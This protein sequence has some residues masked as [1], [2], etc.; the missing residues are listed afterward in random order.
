MLPNLALITSVSHMARSEACQKNVWMPV[1][2]SAFLPASSTPLF[3]QTFQ[4]IL[5][6]CKACVITWQNKQQEA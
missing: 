5:F 6:R 4:W 1:N 3:E 2:C